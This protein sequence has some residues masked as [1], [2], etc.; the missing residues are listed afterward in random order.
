MWSV[1]GTRE[2]PCR[3]VLDYV[4]RYLRNKDLFVTYVSIKTQQIGL[5]TDITLPRLNTKVCL[6]VFLVLKIYKSSQTLNWWRYTKCLKVSLGIRTPSILQAT[7]F[8]W[9]N[10]PDIPRSH[11]HVW[12]FFTPDQWREVNYEEPRN[13]MCDPFLWPRMF[14]LFV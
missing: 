3:D 2:E 9:R 5:N 7:F 6:T 4:S 14:P 13:P 1:S 12:P 10:T 8:S 11:N